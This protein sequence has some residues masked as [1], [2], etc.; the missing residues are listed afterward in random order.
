ME[1]SSDVLVWIAVLALALVALAKK[2]HDSKAGKAAAH[3]ADRT[4]SAAASPA[5]PELDITPVPPGT[6]LKDI[7]KLQLRPYRP[8]YHVRAL[9]I[10]T[11][12]RRC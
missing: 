9:V 11:E 4:A 5:H 1:I 8:V 6:E 12:R 10:W 2:F 7:E 3:P